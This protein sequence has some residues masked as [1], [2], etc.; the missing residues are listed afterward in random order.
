MALPH[1]SNQC[2]NTRHTES[3]CNLIINE[4]KSRKN[5]KVASGNENKFENAADF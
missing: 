5:K 2:T 3:H 1:V 4:I